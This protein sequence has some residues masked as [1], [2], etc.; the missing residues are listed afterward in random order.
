M[1]RIG[2]EDVVVSSAKENVHKEESKIIKRTRLQ[3]Y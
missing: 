1:V 2:K 3:F